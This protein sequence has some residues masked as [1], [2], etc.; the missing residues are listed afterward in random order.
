M[1]HVW[2]ICTIYTYIII[3]VLNSFHKSVYAVAER[4]QSRRIMH[5]VVGTQF[6]LVSSMHMHIY[7]SIRIYVFA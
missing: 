5:A 6:G 4:I 2:N 3:F 1:K 7:A